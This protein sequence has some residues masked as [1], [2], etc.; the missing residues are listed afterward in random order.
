MN[1]HT[2]S[3]ATDHNIHASA[4]AG[5]CIKTEC[6]QQNYEMKRKS[7]KKSKRE[8]N[9]YLKSVFIFLATQ[10]FQFRT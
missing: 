1:S 4:T 6:Q 7:R 2:T 5:G 8:A 10:V 9:I 3:Y